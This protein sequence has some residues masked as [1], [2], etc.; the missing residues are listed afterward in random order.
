MKVVLQPEDFPKIIDIGASKYHNIFVEK[1]NSDDCGAC[2]MGDKIILISKNHEEGSVL[3][4]FW[5]E[6]LHAFEEEY[7]IKLGHPLI[8]KLEHA[9]AQVHAQFYVKGK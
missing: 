4:T 5:H 8:E 9:I 7:K 1:L 2:D 6:V 3:A